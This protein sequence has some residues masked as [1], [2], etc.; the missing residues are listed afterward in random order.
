MYNK[1]KILHRKTQSVF[2]FKFLMIRL[3]SR[4]HPAANPSPPFPLCP[5]AGQRGR[6][7]EGL[8]ETQLPHIFQDGVSPF[9]PGWPRGAGSCCWPRWP[10]GL[11]HSPAVLSGTRPARCVSTYR[12]WCWTLWPLTAPSLRPTPPPRGVPR[13]RHR[14]RRRPASPPSATATVTM[15]EVHTV[16]R[17]TRAAA[18]SAIWE[19]PDRIAMPTRRGSAADTAG[20]W[21]CRALTKRISAAELWRWAPRCGWAS[22]TRLEVECIRA[23]TASLWTL[24]SDTGT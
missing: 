5:A 3:L 11:W 15:A 4:H 14:R 18:R 8:A 20:D 13:R 1:L 16:L 9:A 12:R 7:G 23:P 21:R 2:F 6:G 19:C 24:S 17:A 10:A 22:P